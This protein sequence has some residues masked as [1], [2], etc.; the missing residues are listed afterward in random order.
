MMLRFGFL[1]LGL[2]LLAGWGLVVE[3]ADDAK[4]K[5]TISEVM[6]EAHKKGL[7]TKVVSGK[8]SDAEKK[9]LCELY[10]S[11]A[12]NKPP[13]GSA[14]EW[15]SKTDAIVAACKKG[16]PKALKAAVNCGVCH[17]AHR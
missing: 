17:K 10:E 1:A 7:L 6:I 3:A 2:G 12:A 11:L 14:V 15:K 8:A 4:P 9:Q 5:H 16:D 13:K